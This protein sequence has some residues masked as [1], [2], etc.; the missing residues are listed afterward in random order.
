MEGTDPL[1]MREA[2]L[3][4]QDKFDAGVDYHIPPLKPM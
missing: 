2:Y 1:I 3:A 4:F